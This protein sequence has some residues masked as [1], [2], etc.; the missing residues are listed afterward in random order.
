ME[1]IVVENGNNRNNITYSIVEMTAILKL[2][3]AI[4]PINELDRDF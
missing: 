4:F 2:L 3:E 1:P